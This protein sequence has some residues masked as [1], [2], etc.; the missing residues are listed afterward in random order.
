MTAAY[1]LL[2]PEQVTHATPQL[3]TLQRVGGSMGTAML[4]VVL[5][6]HLTTARRHRPVRRTPSR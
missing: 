5:Q 6:H 1:A 2:R 4:T 3:T